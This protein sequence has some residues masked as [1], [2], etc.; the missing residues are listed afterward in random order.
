MGNSTTCGATCRSQQS[1]TSPLIP[2]G[3][4]LN[5]PSFFEPRPSVSLI[6]KKICSS[7]YGAGIR[8]G[9]WHGGQCFSAEPEPEVQDGNGRERAGGIE[10]GIVG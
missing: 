8:R 2:E 6:D 3:A 9:F 10:K 4:G 7:R 1:R 5:P